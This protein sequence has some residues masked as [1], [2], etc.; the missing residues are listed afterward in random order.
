MFLDHLDELRYR[1]TEDVIELVGRVARHLPGS[2]L[3]T[4]DDW[5]R[6]YCRALGVLGSALRQRERLRAAN[7]A[8][9][10]ALFCAEVWQLRG[11]EARLLERACYLVDDCGEPAEALRLADLAT[12]IYA[13][14]HDMLGI[15]RV[16]VDRGQILNRLGKAKDASRAFSEAL[17]RL[18]ANEV[19]NR[20]A[21]YTGF[22][23]AEQ[24]L[25]R[26]EVAENALEQARQLADP[27][28][29][30]T[31]ASL[32]YRQAELAVA[33]GELH[34]AE[35]LYR[36]ARRLLAP[37]CALDIA[38]VS[39]ALCKTLLTLGNASEA[40]EV[41]SAMV[42]LLIPLDR[43]KIAA[44]ALSEFIKAAKSGKFSI[45]TIDKT[46]KNLRRRSQ[47]KETDLP[48]HS[49]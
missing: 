27:R 26:L 49:G 47:L 7:R 19:R 37:E 13:G 31:S 1:Q 44:A 15:T 2:A 25:G 3:A 43:N 36:E 23:N 14:L 11:E 38:L 12:R 46:K 40:E 48:R 9:R 24:K 6:L 28:E 30:M 45:E 32:A 22:A 42:A 18:P 20:A 17:A 10:E 39:L 34:E 8:L 16:L 29:A 35:A 33:R 4:C 5:H 21:A 41:A